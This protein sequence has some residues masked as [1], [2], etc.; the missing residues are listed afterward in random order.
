MLSWTCR[1]FR[2]RFTP[3]SAHPHR[4]ACRGCD[5]FASAVE[6]AAGTRL[7]LPPRLGRRLQSIALAEDGPAAVLPFP[8]PRLPLPPAMASRLRALAPVRRPAPPDWVLS[9]R[10]ALA[11][12]AVLAL[13]LGP[14]I[15][16]AADRGREAVNRVLQGVSPLAAHT[17][18][19]S[20][21]ELAKLRRATSSAEDEAQRAAASLQEISSRW[22]TFIH[23]N[24]TRRL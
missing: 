21:Q 20:R 2:A 15:T 24:L 11:A 14:F 5:A 12:S 9:P 13:L 7:P 17:R 1:R 22:S 16:T 3:G 19:N 23:D 18:E 4:R 8:V 6:Q 10:Y